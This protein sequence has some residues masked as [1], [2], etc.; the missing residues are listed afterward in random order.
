MNAT[1]NISYNQMLLLLQQMPVRSQ[2]RIGKALTRQNIRAELN[3]FLETFRTEDI[4]E[5]D[6]MAEVKAVRRERHAKKA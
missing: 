2:L 1:I 4:S 5:E 3:H 6:I